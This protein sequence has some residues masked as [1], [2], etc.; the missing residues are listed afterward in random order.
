MTNILWKH[1]ITPDLL[2]QFSASSMSGFLDIRVVETGPDYLVATMP[3]TDK[4]VQP[5]GIL[6]GGASVVLAESL[7]SMAS[8]LCIENPATHTAVGVEINANH[9]KSVPKGETVTATCR[10]VRIGRQLHVWQI[11]CTMPRVFAPASAA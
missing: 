11:D 8:N 1:P 3:V 4:N 10:P 6:H 9:L 5:F 2:N 7:G